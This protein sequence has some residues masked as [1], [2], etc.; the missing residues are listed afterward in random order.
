ML[1][2]LSIALIV[3]MFIIIIP[4]TY[5]ADRGT[6]SEAQELVKKAVALIKAEG[7]SAY[8]KLQ[9]AKGKYVVKDL[10]I[11]VL[12]VKDIFCK[13]HPMMPAM[14]GK[15]WVGL[16][17]ADGKP[18]VAQ[19]VSTA[20]GVGGGWVEYRWTSPISKKIEDKMVYFEK[21]GDVVVVCGFYK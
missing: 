17:D 11:Y 12:T 14:V 10:Y 8:P 6:K 5:A 7:E 16:K 20:T 21:I 1:K 4:F 9:D 2:N 18:F 19:I 13:V 15:S 3:A